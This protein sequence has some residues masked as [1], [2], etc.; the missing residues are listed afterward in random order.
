MLLGDPAEKTTSAKAMKSS[1]A[2]Q[3]SPA[4]LLQGS[5]ETQMQSSGIGSFTS[6]HLLGLL[7]ASG[8]SFKLADYRLGFMNDLGLAMRAAPMFLQLVR[9]QAKEWT[10]TDVWQEA[11]ARHGEKTA[12]VFENRRLSFLDME[13]TV[14]QMARWLQGKGIQK[15]DCVA[16][17]LENKP[18]FI[19]WWLAVTRLGGLVS[20]LNYNIKGEGLL[21]C[22]RA[23]GAM[24]VVADP[25]TEE[26]LAEASAIIAT[27]AQ[28]S[29]RKFQIFFWDSKYPRRLE[30]SSNVQE[31]YCSASPIE[32]HTVTY[33]DLLAIPSR[34]LPQ[35]LR[36]GIKFQDLFGYIYTS[37]TTGLPKAAKVPHMRMWAFGG[38][39]SALA[40]IRDDDT[41]YTCLPIF[42]SAGGGI[43][44]MSMM[45]TGATL[46]LSRR[47][48]ASRFWEEVAVNKCTV[49]QYIGEL[50]R[51]LLVQTKGGESESW[52]HCVRLAVGNGL[53][54]E[55]WNDFQTRFG[56]SEVLEFYGA[57]E[58]N[59]AMANRC[60]VKSGVKGSVGRYGLIARKIMGLKIVK[61][62]VDFE[63]PMR[64]AKTKLC[65]EAEF[66]EP[67][68][69][70]FPVKDCLPHTRFS[71]YSD[72]AASAKKI[73]RNV[74]RDGD[75]YVRTGDLL[76]L[77][78]NGYYYFV[79]RIGDTFRWKGENVSTTEVE[80]VLAEIPGVA[81]AN[82][83]GVQVPQQPDG[84]ACMAA[85]TL[86]AKVQESPESASSQQLS[87]LLTTI[88]QTCRKQL[89]AYAVPIFV[90]I[91]KTD[92]S[93]TATLK[94]QKV[95]LRKEGCDPSGCAPDVLFWLEDGL[96]AKGAP[97]SG[98]SS[99][100]LLD[101]DTFGRLVATTTQGGGVS[102]L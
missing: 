90:R 12:V 97:S 53:R 31:Q 16:I 79:D 52:P 33:D 1:Q 47:F 15:G 21:H 61:F 85:L 78:R 49:V 35:D 19:C 2:S 41:I 5:G 87:S 98:S 86:D 10:L 24:A 22:L 102:K 4:P 59:G 63:E 43:G 70:L 37:G 83:Y 18:E 42:H 26:R 30:W 76:K 38:M 34:P 67:G 64:D 14:V 57:T 60:H 95:D 39:V 89:P 80:Q 8:V 68:E 74:F 51:Y 88:L 94:V 6:K 32:L 84:R 48:S 75:V 17:Y 73:L 55:I 99:Y 44:V 13:R 46:V 45:I 29:R 25:D 23:C 7:A 66:D 82:V 77:D 65:V 92:M 20:L 96:R 91:L 69:L 50:C 28:G 72:D 9:A 101:A 36:S 93:H 62:D 71:G 27:A 40:G 3:R 56:V 54:P 81:E 11:V 100:T 58:G